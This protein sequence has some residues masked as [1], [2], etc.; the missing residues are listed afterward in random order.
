MLGVVG[1]GEQEQTVD[2]APQARQLVR[3]HI[4]VLDDGRVGGATL[5]Q[6]GVTEGDRDRRPELVRS[7][8][9]ESPLTLEEPE[10]LHGHALGLLHGRQ[11]LHQLGFRQF[12]VLAG[13]GPALPAS[14]LFRKC[15]HK[16]C[17]L[18]S[19]SH[20]SHRRPDR[21]LAI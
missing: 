12:F 13:H 19:P 4:D 17:R 21:R 3:D 11:P 6:L 20:L 18:C 8:L 5:D 10:V 2:Q 1:P 9:D 14:R 7:V 16:R 15:Q